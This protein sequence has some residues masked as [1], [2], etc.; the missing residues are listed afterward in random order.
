MVA[1]SRL[2]ACTSSGTILGNDQRRYMYVGV[3]FTK[4]GVIYLFDD[5]NRT[6]DNEKSCEPNRNGSQ[7]V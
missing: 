1:L 7:M 2:P 4:T 5:A 3:I 6:E